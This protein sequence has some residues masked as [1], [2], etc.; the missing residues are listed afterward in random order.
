[1]I[2]YCS[3]FTDLLPSPKVTQLY[4]S[5]WNVSIQPFPPGQPL[6]AWILALD[7]LVLQP[8]S[9]LQAAP[10]KTSSGAYLAPWSM[11]ATA[12]T[13]S[14]VCPGGVTASKVSSSNQNQTLGSAASPVNLPSDLPSVFRSGIRNLTIQVRT[15]VGLTFNISSVNPFDRFDCF[16]CNL[17]M[18]VL[19]EI[20][21]CNR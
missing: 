6:F 8:L 9:L 18:I 4:A 12:D 1:M 21:P 5:V 20:L 2:L 16:G 7:V 11:L 3:I 19:D 17:A 10:A 13:L 15:S 14:L